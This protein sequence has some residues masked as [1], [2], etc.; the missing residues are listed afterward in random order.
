M[1]KSRNISNLARKR[2]KSTRIAFTATFIS[3]VFA[4]ALGLVLK[5]QLAEGTAQ[6]QIQVEKSSGTSIQIQELAAS[7][8][9]SPNELTGSTVETNHL[10]QDV[11]G[12]LISATSFRTE[13]NLVKADVCFELPD[14]ADWIIWEAALQYGSGESTAFWGEPIE[15]R[16]PAVDGQQRVISFEAGN[17]VEHLESAMDGQGGQRCDTLAFEVPSGTDLA[18]LSLVIYEIAALPNEDEECELYENKV[19]VELDAQNTDIR[20]VCQYEEW[21]ANVTLI[22][23]PPSMSQAEAEAI[24]FNDPRFEAMFSIE[25]PWIFVTSLD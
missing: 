6:A 3:A 19:Q 22:S 15:L 18:N 20:I 4:L 23:K 9:K 8:E 10:L 12:V 1:N 21:G 13:G 11:N 24:V 25:G 17:K 16:F 2:K 7:I 14:D 5:S